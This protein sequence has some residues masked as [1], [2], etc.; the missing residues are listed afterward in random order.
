M[1]IIALDPGV[2]TGVAIYRSDDNTPGRDPFE[3]F[4]FKG[5]HAEFW[6]IVLQRDDWNAIVY[7]KFTYQRRDRVE[8]YPVQVIGVIRMY[9]QQEDIPEFSHTAS[10][11]KGL[12]TDDKL[13]KMGLWIPNLRHAMDATR[14]LMYHLIV[15]RGEPQW[16][17]SLRP[18]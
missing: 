14:H 12:I 4:Q 5:S 10:A 18:R 1:R 2:T 9:A 16:L 11:A 7:E 13:K 17:E 3:Q 8:L 15:T 6:D